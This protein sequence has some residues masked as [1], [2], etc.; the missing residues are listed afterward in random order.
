MRARAPIADTQEWIDKETI[1]KHS[2]AAVPGA[3]FLF[4][5]GYALAKSNMIRLGLGAIDPE[6]SALDESL[7]ALEVAFKR[8]KRDAN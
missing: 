8:S 4:R 6:G 2:L 7:S 5:N 3:F 1:P